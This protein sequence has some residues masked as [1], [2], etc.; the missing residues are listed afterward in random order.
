MKRKKG[1]L[2]LLSIVMVI[3]GIILFGLLYYMEHGSVPYQHHFYGT[4]SGF[5]SNSFRRMGP[6]GYFAF[7]A[8]ALVDFGCYGIYKAISGEE[9]TLFHE[10]Q[11][12]FDGKPDEVREKAEDIAC[13]YCKN[14]L[15]K[16]EEY[17]PICGRKI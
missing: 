1:K 8:F 12:A 4:H 10:I 13:P 7:L 14:R 3:L 17:C 16:K 2:L 15:T 9:P 5:H 11:D 6:E